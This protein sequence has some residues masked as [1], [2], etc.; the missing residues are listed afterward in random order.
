VAAFLLLYL[1][2]TKAF[3][4]PR[5]IDPISRV[6][7]GTA[8]L[9]H[10]AG[11]TLR[12][13]AGFLLALAAAAGTAWL[14]KRSTVGFEI[15][16]IGA[17]PDAARAAGMDVEHNYSLVMLLAGGLAG[18]AGAS[19]VL[20]TDFTLTP[21][22]AGTYG[23]DAITLALLGRSNPYGVVLAALLFGGLHAGGVQMQ[24]ATQTPVDIVTV[25]QSLIV[26]FIAAPPLVRA[27]FRLR[28]QRSGADE[29]TLQAVGG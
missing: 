5:R 15:R 6:V 7:H 3:R 1:L 21:G 8:R 25:I 10:L 19:V 23:F 27:I 29:T 18:L 9:P 17:N 2:G 13:N 11:G 16:T 22:I 26:L 4:R 28:G 24:A 14:I 20:G 12:M